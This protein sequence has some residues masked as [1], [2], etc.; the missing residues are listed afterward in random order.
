MRLEDVEEMLAPPAG[1][2]DTPQQA[3]MRACLASTLS[4]HDAAETVKVASEMIKMMRDQL[5]G[6]VALARRRAAAQA[7][8]E[9]TKQELVAASGQTAATISRLLTESRAS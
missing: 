3:Q 9:M 8:G 4:G 1:W 7:R 5:L 2:V 6:G